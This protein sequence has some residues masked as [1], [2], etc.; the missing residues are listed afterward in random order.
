M[1][2]ILYKYYS[3]DDYNFK[4]V[5]QGEFFFSKASRLN[6]PFDA[7][8]SLIEPNKEFWE[9]CRQNFNAQDMEKVK[10]IM[11]NYGTCSFSEDPDNKHL[12]AL[13]AQSYHG[14]VV[15]YNKEKLENMTE[16][17]G[18]FCRLHKVH[19]VCCFPNL[20]DPEFSFCELQKNGDC[21][22]HPIGA[23]L[24]DLKLMDKLWEYLCT[25]KEKQI[26]ENEKEWRLFAGRH[27]VE[28]DAG[29][30]V[31]K[32][33]K[34]Y[35]LPMPKDSIKEFIIGHNI[36]DENRY[37]IYSLAQKHH[38]EHVKITHPTTANKEFEIELQEDSRYNQ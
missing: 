21:I 30:G 17:V 27:I 33:E 38:V 2:N 13:Y 16:T 31:K 35:L 22:Q 37:C 15:G 6:D 25:V 12:W 19:Y 9:R 1:S 20:D 8:A 32:L 34:G 5:C 36:S 23:C 11:D 3:P 28:L 7:S 4:A 26:W 29:K 18:A 14:F 24:H 10:E